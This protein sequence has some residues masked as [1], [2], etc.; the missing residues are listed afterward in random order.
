MHRDAAGSL[1]R[2]ALPYKIYVFG[3]GKDL[4]A[5]ASFRHAT[6]LP[7]QPYAYER[8]GGDADDQRGHGDPCGQ[9]CGLHVFLIVV[10]EEDMDQINPE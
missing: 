5:K 8:R 2:Y 7:Q 4:F 6:C 1:P 3:S 9:V 10:Q